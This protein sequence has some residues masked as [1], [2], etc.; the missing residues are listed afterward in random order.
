[1]LDIW[2]KS[3]TFPSAVLGRLS[4]YLKEAEKGAYRCLRLFAKYNFCLRNFSNIL[5]HTAESLSEDMN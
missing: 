4:Q 5:P 2:I 3:N 1:M